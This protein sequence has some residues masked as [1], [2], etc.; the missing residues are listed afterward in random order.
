MSRRGFTM[1][2]LLLSLAITAVVA[3]GVA[4]MLG[5][6][7]TGIALGSDARTGLLATAAT[8]GRLVEELVDTG[9]VLA[10]KDDDAVLWKGDLTP[11]G[12]ID[13]S[14]LRWIT[15]DPERGELY[16]SS[17]R[18]PEDWSTIDRLTFDRPIIRASQLS[19]EW[20]RA[21]SRGILEHEILADGL[22]FARSSAPTPFIEATE[23]RI[24]LTFD[25]AT[26]P[27]EATT[28]IICHGD[29]P[30]EWNP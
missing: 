26:G 10:I 30:S 5:G 12:L 17:I 24:D 20:N 18:F 19:A 11:G 28:V 14:E 4:A 9:C 25:L 6:L 3:A 8:H 15:F 1:I 13:P 21:E 27:V 23:F 2:E 7:A 29:Q 16:R 22:L